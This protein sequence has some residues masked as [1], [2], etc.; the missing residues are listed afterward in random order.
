MFVF[1]AVVAATMVVVSCQELNQII[2]GIQDEKLEVSVKS[3][4]IPA[5]GGEATFI[6]DSPVTWT[7]KLSQDW[8][9][10]TPTGSEK[11]KLSVKV[12]AEK[13]PAEEARTAII[14]LLVNGK[15]VADITVTQDG[16]VNNEPKEGSSL[17]DPTNGGNW[18]W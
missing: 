13:N 2:P 4:T 16:A 15:E 14:S 9:A 12:S 6:V 18:N 10:I 3:L 8:L 17:E 1:L 7:A 11:G 5:E